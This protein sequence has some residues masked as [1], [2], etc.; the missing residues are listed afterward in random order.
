MGIF[1]KLFNLKLGC[2]AYLQRSSFKDLQT[3]LR[4][5]RLLVLVKV[6]WIDPLNMNV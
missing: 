2:F 6:L 4:I 3:M 5:N 1:I